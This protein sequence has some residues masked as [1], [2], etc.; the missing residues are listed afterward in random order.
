MIIYIVVYHDTSLLIIWWYD[1]GYNGMSGAIQAFG[2]SAPGLRGS[3]GSE[4]Q[5][6]QR[7]WPVVAIERW[8]TMGKP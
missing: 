7:L 1:D 3:W 4:T 2:S 6:A 8:E 5:T